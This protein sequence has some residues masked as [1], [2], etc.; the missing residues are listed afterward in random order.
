MLGKVH[1]KMIDILHGDCATCALSE[2]VVVFEVGQRK[3]ICGCIKG[4][5]AGDFLGSLWSSFLGREKRK[6][7]RPIVEFLM[8]VKCVQVCCLMKNL[9]G[10]VVVTPLPPKAMKWCFKK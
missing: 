2:L 5:A 4:R 8:E 6:C 9:E 10:C 3:G 7:P 1:G